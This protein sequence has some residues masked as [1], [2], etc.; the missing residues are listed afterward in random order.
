[1]GEVTGEPSLAGKGSPEQ[2]A[3]YPRLRF[4]RHELAGSF[5]DL[6]LAIPL[7]TALI[8]TN[9]LDPASVL[10]T[11]GIMHI[12]TGLVFGIP[13]PVQP[14]KAMAAIMITSSYPKSYLFGGGLVVGAFFALLGLTKGIERLSRLIPQAAIR[15]I[16]IGL[17]A[18]LAQIA[19]RYMGRESWEG[20]LLAGLGL[21]VTLALQGNRRLPAAIVLVT[22]GIGYAFT[23]DLRLGDITGGFAVHGPQL[24][25]PS[26]NDLLQGTLLLAIPQI[27]LSL[28]NSVIATSLLARD[29]FPGRA[30]ESSTRKLSLTYGAMNLTV[31]WL[32]GMP[33]CHGAGGLAAH[34]KFGARTGG[35]VVIIGAMFLL[36]G[37]FFSDALSSV[38]RLFPFP[39]LGILLFFAALE[40][41]NTARKAVV[42]W[43]DLAIA[44]VVAAI[45]FAV[46]YGYAIGLGVGV[47]AYFMLQRLRWTEKWSGTLQLNIGIGKIRLS[48]R[49][50]AIDKASP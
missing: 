11:F 24:Y 47:A 20:W 35:A 38:V 36:T 19:V 17:A 5:G 25:T 7:L 50:G 43:D 49:G 29:L 30:S 10:I 31:P 13:M 34:Y 27:P 37:L 45:A 44:A 4:D 46:P 15:G 14:L 12:Y 18:N 3:A 8:V 2:Q 22:L 6:G 48:L 28:S 32:S 39:I 1:M 23:Q 9:A 26:P 16:Q 41:F 21:L 33:V 40:L 42:R